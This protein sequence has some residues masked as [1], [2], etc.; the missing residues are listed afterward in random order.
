M[1]GRTTTRIQNNNQMRTNY[2]QGQVLSQATLRLF[3][4]E[5][6][7]RLQEEGG[8]LG[9]FAANMYGSRS[10]KNPVLL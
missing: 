10:T 8:Y 9:C 1:R 5:G 2:Q 7:F 3:L 4:Q 6:K